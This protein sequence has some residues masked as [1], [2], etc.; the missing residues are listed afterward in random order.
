MEKIREKEKRVVMNPNQNKLDKSHSTGFSEGL[1]NPP[2]INPT[3]RN[4]SG[5]FLFL[6]HHISEKAFSKKLFGPGQL[7]VFF[8]E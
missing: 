6:A 5:V 4:V 8:E 1:I 3:N 2:L 7:G